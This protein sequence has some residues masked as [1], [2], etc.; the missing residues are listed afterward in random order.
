MNG[1]GCHPRITCDQGTWIYRGWMKNSYLVL[2][3][4]TLCNRRAGFSLNK[5]TRDKGFR[6]IEILPL[7]PSNLLLKLERWVF[8]CFDGSLG[9][10]AALRPGC[11]YRVVVHSNFVHMA[12]GPR[13]R[14]PHISAKG[15]RKTGVTSYT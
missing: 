3:E 14:M 8:L 2:H 4:K 15:S 12:R 10:T 11:V 7:R 1:G 5:L 13:C 6:P 9:I